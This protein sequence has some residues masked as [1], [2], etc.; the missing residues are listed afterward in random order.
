[1]KS[2]VVYRALS[3]FKENIFKLCH[4]PT[5]MNKVNLRDS[6]VLR[7]G[8]GVSSMSALQGREVDLSQV[9]WAE[10]GGSGRAPGEGEGGGR[11]YHSRLCC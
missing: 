2:F 10:V 7:S 8:D 9:K 3:D 4:D 6:Q 11:T 1:M 5:W